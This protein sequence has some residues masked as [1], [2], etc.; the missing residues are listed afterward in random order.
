MPF[1]FLNSTSYF[2]LYTVD[3]CTLRFCVI[4]FEHYCGNRAYRS[5]SALPSEWASFDHDR[6][7]IIV[8]G[9]LPQCLAYC[10]QRLETPK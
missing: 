10:K 6:Q 2:A 1:V 4:R 5:S 3:R 9:L 7:I 8:I